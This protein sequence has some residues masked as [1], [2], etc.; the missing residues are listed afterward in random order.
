MKT[1]SLFISMLIVFFFSAGVAMAQ[2]EDDYK[3][4][5]EQ[6]NKQM[7]EYMLKGDTEKTMDL[8]T[9]DAI[10]LPSYEPMHQGIAEIREAS[11]R[12]TESG[13]KFESFEPNIVKIIPMGDLVAEI[14][15]YNVSMAMEGSNKPMKDKGKYLTIWEKQDDGTLKIKVETWNSDVDPATMMRSMEQ[16]ADVDVDID[17]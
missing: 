3:D 1:V 14:G 17:E 4:Q 10:S 2:T 5:I 15:T 11:K 16:Q 7:V 6:R 9:E 12:M 8:Y 13:W